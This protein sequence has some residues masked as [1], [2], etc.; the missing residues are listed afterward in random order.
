MARQDPLCRGWWN[1]RRDDS[2]RLGVVYYSSLIG[3]SLPRDKDLD[4]KRSL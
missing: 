2:Y 4:D 1:V 3:S